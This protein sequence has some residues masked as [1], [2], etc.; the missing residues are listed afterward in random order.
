M[1]G[2]GINAGLRDPRGAQPP[3]SRNF[4]INLLKHVQFGP[5]SNK[6]ALARYQSLFDYIKRYWKLSES[7][8][9]VQEFDLEECFSLLESQKIDCEDPAVI[10]ELTQ[11]E[12]LLIGLLRY[13]LASFNVFPMLTDEANYMSHLAYKRL[14]KLIYDSGATV[15]TFNYD[16]LLESMIAQESGLRWPLNEHRRAAKDPERGARFKK[17]WEAARAYGLEFDSVEVLYRDNTRRFVP[18][19]EYYTGERGKPHK[20]YFLKMHG[21]LDWFRHAGVWGPWGQRGEHTLTPDRTVLLQRPAIDHEFLVG[22]NGELLEPLVIT[23]TVWKKTREPPFDRIWE[24][25]R[26]ELSEC[27][28]LVVG[29]YSFPPTDFRARR[30]FLEAFADRQ[31]PQVWMIDPDRTGSVEEILSRTGGDVR[32]SKD[33]GEFMEQEAH[34]VYPACDFPMDAIEAIRIARGFL[35]GHLMHPSA[36]FLEGDQW[37]LKFG[38]VSGTDLTITVDCATG[39]AAFAP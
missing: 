23:P 10:Q 33:L 15:L 28:M 9:R 12:Q 5:S 27:H 34:A 32:K 25:A 36:S 31:P 2:A 14:G 38:G 20:G 1:F 19:G 22:E 26:T 30:V 8:L 3:F 35:G 16:H 29:G 4:F 18:A 37:R 24:L 21:S 13:F 7:D 17:N 6:V 39:K 11:I